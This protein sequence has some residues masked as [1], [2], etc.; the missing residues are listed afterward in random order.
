MNKCKVCGQE[1]KNVHYCSIKCRD[2]ARK[3]RAF[4]NVKCKMC[5]KDVLCRVSRQNVYC[6]NKC[7]QS[8]PDK[9]ERV[10]KTIKEKFKD[11]EY[12]NKI[13]ETTKQAM[14]KKYGKEYIVDTPDVRE[15]SKKTMQERHGVDY[16]QQSDEI[17]EKSKQTFNE[18]FGGF[19]FQSKELMGRIVKTKLEKYGDV[20]YNNPESIK[21]T[22]LDQAFQNIEDRCEGSIPIFERDDYIGTKN[23]KYPFICK[24]CG[25]IYEDNIENGHTPKCPKCFPPNSSKAEIEVREYIQ[26]LIPNEIILTNVRKPLDNKFEL[27][28]FIPSRNLAF[29]YHGLVWHSENFGQKSRSYHVNKVEA[30]DEK[31]IHLIQILENEWLVKQDIVKSKIRH[32]LGVYSEKIYA[33]DCTIMEI[34]NQMKADFLKKYHLQGNDNAG[35]RFGAFHDG[36]LVAVMTLGKARVALGRKKSEE[37]EYELYR[38]CVNKRVIGIGGKLMAHFIKSYN[39]SKIITFADRRYS[40]KTNAF[41][42][43]IGFKFIG[44]SKP[45]Y[46]YFTLEDLG[47][48]KHR[49]NFRKDQLPKKLKM[50]DPNLT[51]WENMKANGYDR[52]WDSGNL[53]YEMILK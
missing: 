53:K 49:F 17:K 10:S 37:G 4:V 25:H 30:C 3:E 18:K 14:L 33:R 31:G 12:K 5:G 9:R 7:S 51:E 41:Y 1:T 28:I 44:Y 46:Y 6:S 23:T 24:C 22:K 43:K 40:T 8:D 36:E 47:S 29:E 38:F 11:P 52:I 19:T 27:D 16:A 39:P 35:I 2:V 21:K 34:N 20:N 42:E 45:N 32:L 13:I 48:L 50:F 15:K 26:S